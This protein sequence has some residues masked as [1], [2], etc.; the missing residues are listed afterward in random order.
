[1][2]GG[3]GR[4]RERE[5]EKKRKREES[6]IMAYSVTALLDIFVVLSSFREF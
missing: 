5:R 2:C 1:V 4:E 3:R 6:D